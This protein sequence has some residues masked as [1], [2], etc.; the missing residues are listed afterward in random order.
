MRLLLLP[1]RHSAQQRPQLWPG[2]RGIVE[3]V[4]E[5]IETLGIEREQTLI[6]QNVYRQPPGTL[7]HEFRTRLAKDRCRIVDELAG[8]GLNAQVDAAFRIRR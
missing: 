4:H 6:E 3:H 1:C 7:N 5:G 8:I 2:R